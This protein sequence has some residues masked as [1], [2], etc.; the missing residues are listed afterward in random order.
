MSRAVVQNSVCAALFCSLCLLCVLSCSPGENIA[1]GGTDVGNA[2]VVCGFVNPD[3][4]PVEGAKIRVRSSHYLADT[5]GISNSGIDSQHDGA[6]D[7]N[8]KF[9]IQRL[10]PGTYVVEA[11]SS[12]STAAILSFRFAQN[13]RQL[14][15]DPDTLRPPSTVTGTVEIPDSLRKRSAYAFVEGLER[16]SRVDSTGRFSIS[17]VPRGDTV[18]VQVALYRTSNVVTRRAPLPIVQDT[19][20][21][22]EP[23]SLPIDLSDDTLAVRRQLNAAGHTT[24]S[25]LSVVTIDSAAQR[26]S[27]LDLA[28]LGIDSL[29]PGIARL[30]SCRS[31]DLTGNSLRNLPSQL[32]D[33]PILRELELDSN[34]L[35]QVPPQLQNLQQLRLIS[36]AANQIDSI[37][38]WLT[39]LSLIETIQLQSNNIDSVPHAM[40][41]LPRLRTFS[42]SDNRIRTIPASVGRSRVLQN[43]SFSANLLTSIPDS[44]CEV[45]VLDAIHLSNN[46][47]TAVPECIGSL[48]S[49]LTLELQNNDLTTLPSSITHLRVLGHLDVSDNSL[50]TP[51]STLQSYLDEK[52][53]GW[54]STQVC[55]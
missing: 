50:C 4:S 19:A 26:V 30:D 53:P 39:T 43:L 35:G 44:L 41:D 37:P 40:F 5:S 52:N 32:A 12:D 28:Y 45:T 36:L 42:V 1:G 10:D 24:T 46:Q 54:D 11:L 27:S 17:G 18:T 7:R 49:L 55:Q 6:T 47:L 25:V 16:V 14:Q 23:V 2:K 48:R 29:L 34:E 22:I 8:G 20:R 13:V 3:G 38:I 33:M 15:L 21:V 31:I 51:D 9:E